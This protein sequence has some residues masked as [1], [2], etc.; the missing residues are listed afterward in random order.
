MHRL[1]RQIGRVLSAG[2]LSSRHALAAVIR[3]AGIA[4]VVAV[5]RVVIGVRVG[6]RVVGCGCGCEILAR[7]AGRD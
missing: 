7:T 2:G 4:V 3:A 1:R 5:R 6:V